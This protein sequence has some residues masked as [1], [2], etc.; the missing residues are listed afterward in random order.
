MFII[1]CLFLNT[2]GRFYLISE[3]SDD[4]SFSHLKDQFFDLSRLMLKLKLTM[5]EKLLLDQIQKS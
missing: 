5:L 4:S 1:N 3:I 2:I